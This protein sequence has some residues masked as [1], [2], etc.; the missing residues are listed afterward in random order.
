MLQGKVDSTPPPLRARGSGA[1]FFQLV[2]ARHERASTVLTSN[3]GFEEWGGVLGD[4]VMAAALIDRRSA[5]GRENCWSVTQLGG[6]VPTRSTFSGACGCFSLI[7]ESSEAYSWVT[8]VA[9]TAARCSPCPRPQGCLAEL[10]RVSS[11]ASGVV[12]REN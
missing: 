6:Q 5:D 4:G 10:P 8:C 1:V 12:C 3:K 11:S 2:N 9:A 7:G